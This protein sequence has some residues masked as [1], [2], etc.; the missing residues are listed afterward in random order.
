[1]QIPPKRSFVSS[2]EI[3]VQFHRSLKALWNMED[4]DTNFKIYEEGK[5][6]MMYY[7]AKLLLEL[8]KFFKLGTR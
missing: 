7:T 5:L 1:M 2:K 4:H 8:L 3:D 6:Y